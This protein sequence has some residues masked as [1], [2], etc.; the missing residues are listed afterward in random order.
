MSIQL[1]DGLANQLVDLVLEDLLVRFL[2]N[3]P[4]EDLSL[5]ERV[6]F[7]VEEAQWFYTDF[8]RV[9]NPALP[10]MKMKLFCSKFL[11]KCPLF[12]KWGDPNDALSRFGKYKLTIP[13][14]GV[15]L[16]NRDLTKVLLVKGT[17]SNSW[18]FPRGKISKDESDI[19]CAIREVEEETGFNAKDLINESDVIERTFKGKNYKIYLVRDVPE[20]YNFL[21]VARGEI[22]MIEW[23][24]IKTLQKK[25]RASPNNYFIVETVIKPMIQWIN[26][27]KGG[28][29]EAELM[30]KAEIQLK[31]LLGVGKREE[32]VDAGRELLNI[33][34]KVSPSHSASDSN[35]VPLSSTVP[36]APQ[37][38][39]Y[40]Q[41][42]LPQH[43]QNQIPFF[44][45][46]STHHPQPM[47]PFFNPF[48]FYPGGS[49]LPPHA[50]TPVPMPVP[51]HQIP[52]LN[53]S[54]QK[55]RHPYEIHQPTSESLQKPTGKNSKEFL[56]ILNTKS[57]KITDEATSKDYVRSTEA[58]NNRT[59][60]QD[61][62][63]LVGKQRKESVTS[64][65]R[66]I[67]DL[68]NR[69]QVSSSPSPEQDPGKTLLNILNEKKHPEIVPTRDSRFLGIN[70]PIASNDLEESV[71]HGAGLGLPAPE[72]GK[73]TLLKR[74]DDATE[75]R[76]KK[77][78]DLLSLLGKKPIVQ[79]RQEVK[80]SSNEI[81]DLLKGPKKPLSETTRSPNSSSKELLELLKPK[82]EP[83]A[84]D[85]TS[86]NELLDLLIKNKPSSESEKKPN[87]P[88]LDMLH[89]KAPRQVSQPNAE[90]NHTSANELLGLLNKKPSIPL[91]DADSNFIREEKIE[92]TQFDNFEDFE[93]F[94]DFGVIDN[95]LLG[96]T[97]FRNFDIA[98]DEEDVDHLIDDLGDPYSAPNTAVESFSNPPDFFLDPQ[99]SLEP[100]KGK[101]RLLKPGE[102]LNDIFSTNRPNVSSPPVHASNA[103][104]QNLLALLNGKNPSNSNG[105]IPVSDSFQSIYGNANPT[106]G[107]DSNTPSSLTNAL[108]GQNSPNKN[109]ANFLKD[110]LWKREP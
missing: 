110:I 19:N 24:D 8:V 69:K 16:F 39:N 80:S 50:I 65:S 71:I 28:L 25:I 38:Q 62:L 81:L 1:R 22:A 83:I 46:S 66:S 54:P 99:P 89:S 109:S 20:D 87:N 67:L 108:S 101:I 30:L 26:K 52:F 15:A 14:R 34:Q 78:A 36:G 12:W 33:L 10:N 79:P 86:S 76:R 104:G 51:P 3:C 32:N 60:A 59:K 45:S 56:S 107:L 41:F 100:K 92:E 75:G 64:E 4:E 43:L 61:L 63:N 55:Q 98:S 37:Q 90:H 17:E 73:I 105:A 58:E 103:N 21:P 74:P 85:H 97:S 77:S 9:L 49:P 29:N 47:L 44:S 27:K 11:E 6:F 57:L 53:V 96:K 23:H 95:Q 106:A 5:I 40:I 94:E 68:V 91:N 70:S 93:D 42:A 84:V 31:A 82:K 48:G 35:V 72:P 13:V 102:V 7:Q 2:V 18:S 88:L